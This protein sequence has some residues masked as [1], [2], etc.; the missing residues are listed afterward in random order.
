MQYVGERDNPGSTNLLT[1]CRDL[2]NHP[3]VIRSQIDLF[4]LVVT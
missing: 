4:R 3:N 2:E 1:C